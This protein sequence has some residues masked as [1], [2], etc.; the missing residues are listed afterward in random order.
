MERCHITQ[1]AQSGALVP[2]RGVGSGRREVQD[3]VDTRILMADSC[4]YMAET[5]TAL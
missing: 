4:W 1:G 2:P 3:G 5:S